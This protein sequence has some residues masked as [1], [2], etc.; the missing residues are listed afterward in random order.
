M[1]ATG[2]PPAFLTTGESPDWQPIPINAY[3]RPRGATPMRI[4]LVPAYEQCSSP[5]S[6]HGAPLAFPSCNPPAPTS[7]YL[8]VGTPDANG[9]RTTMEAYILLKTVVGNP[10]TAADEADVKITAR[11]NNV[12]NQ[13]LTDYTGGLWAQ[14]Q[15]QITDRRNMPSPGGPGAATMVQIPFP[16]PVGCTADPDPLVGSDCA[17]STTA[18]ALIPGAVTEGDRAV[19]EI[20]KAQ[21]YD[22]GADGNPITADNTLYATQGVF[23]P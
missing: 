16:F 2:G 18:E 10:F 22:G 7:Q 15:L 6:T 11:V 17:A 12:F 3:P 19:W 4:S 13:D 20:G 5:N 8:T 9:K 21:V 1:N 23:V 14:M